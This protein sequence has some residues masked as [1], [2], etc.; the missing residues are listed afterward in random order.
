MET[1]SSGIRALM[2]CPLLD[3]ARKDRYFLVVQQFVDADFRAHRLKPNV[4]FGSI[5]T[6][7]FHASIEKWSLCPQ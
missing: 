6:D 7:P 3:Q 5:A 4:C 2:P 1:T